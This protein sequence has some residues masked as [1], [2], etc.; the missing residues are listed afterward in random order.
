MPTFSTVYT[1]PGAYSKFLR[2]GLSPDLGA[3]YR[4]PAIIGAGKTL[5]TVKKSLVRGGTTKDSIGVVGVSSIVRVGDS[6]LKADYKLGVDYSLGSGADA[7]KIIWATPGTTVAGGFVVNNLDFG[8][9]ATGITA[10][11]GSGSLVTDSYVLEVTV[12][13]T[14]GTR[15]SYLG[16]AAAG[17]S[18][19]VTETITVTI[20]GTAYPVSLVS[21]DTRAQVVTK[22]QTAVGS[23][24][25]TVSLD[26]SNKLSIITVDHGS[27]KSVAVAITSTTL[28]T[29][30]GVTTP[31]IVAGTSGTGRFTITPRS[32]RLSTTYEAGPGPVTTIPGLSV[33]V[34][35]TAAYASMRAEIVTTA[36]QIA[37]NPLA[38]ATYY[39][40]VDAA[41]QSADYEL[42]FF[43]RED[44]DLVYAEYGDPSASNTL[45]L[46]AYVAFRN[47]AEI[48]GLV[49]L[50]GGTGYSH[51][52][53]AIDKLED[54][55]IYYVCPVS[56]DPLVHA[57]VKSHVASQSA[58]TSRMERMGFVGGG[59]GYTKFDHEDS[60]KSLDDERMVY[61]VPSAWSL[62]YLDT[63]NLQ[64]TVNVDGAFGAVAVAAVASRHD[65]STPLT[66]KQVVGLTPLVTYSPVDQNRL[67][68]SGCALVETRSAV[69]RVRHQLTTDY[70]G[71]IESQE[72]SLIQIRDYVAITLR[73]N[74]ESEYIGSKIL[75]ATPQIVRSYAERILEGLT[76]QEVITEFR[77]VRAWQDEV[78]PTQVN[79]TA[80]VRPV[81]PF[82]YAFIQF[83]FLR[84]AQVV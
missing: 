31:V 35:T 76:S 42:K 81:Y 70:N 23:S 12:A 58:V 38:G 41:K 46:A 24:V 47:Q 17:T 1:A 56:S 11:S 8:S 68:D 37:K 5:K 52:T 73:N 62:T 14:G 48:I 32:T 77:N 34:S 64:S 60:A 22:I 13:G 9:F 3:D 78:D 51:F 49:Q 57:Y 27:T 30:L 6:D 21:G 36:S 54:K 72:I 63:N 75:L 44:E 2:E 10:I 74:L 19:T 53:A 71:P 65:Q 83:K 39:I 45:S 61:V 82:N 25:A 16:D 29:E 40:T 43:A 4:I 59:A 55:P 84:N 18:I 26:G 79:V 7:D 20:N 80:E 67:A 69:S 66:R 28:R 15:A 33:T 50:Q